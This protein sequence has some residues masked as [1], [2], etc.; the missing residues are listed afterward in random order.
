MNLS[1]LLFLN[2]YLIK[3]SYTVI[4]TLVEVWEVSHAISRF[5]QT[6]TRVSME[7]MFSIS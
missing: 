6:S 4:E 7:K 3:C 2:G 5:Y 1:F